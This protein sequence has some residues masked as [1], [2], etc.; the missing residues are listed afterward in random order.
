MPAPKKKVVAVLTR[1][2]P[3]P[4]TLINAPDTKDLDAEIIK[5]P[6]PDNF[7]ITDQASSLVCQTHMIA[8]KKIIKM[9]LDILD[10]PCKAAHDVHSTFTGLRAWYLQDLEKWH[11]EFD[12]MFMDW[13]AAEKRRTELE[14]ARIQREHQERAAADVAAQE[15]ARKLQA[16]KL[17]EDMPW[18]DEAEAVEQVASNGFNVAPVPPPAPVY[19]PP[20]AIATVPGFGLKNKPLSFVV[21]DIKPLIIEC[22]RRLCLDP[23]DT[24]LLRYL[25]VDERQVKATLSEVRETI[26]DVI[27]G[28]RSVQDQTTSSR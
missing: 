27:P 18:L 13:V 28:I 12:R 8:I 5:A 14:N 16:T 2:V 9:G 23:P 11:S 20:P 22:A 3:A 17:L 10:P 26:C 1:P 24:S 7:R 4:Q 19:L 15:A 25:A 21:D 6:R